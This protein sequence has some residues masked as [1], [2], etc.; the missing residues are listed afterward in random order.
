MHTSVLMLWAY[1]DESG[2]HCPQTGHLKKLTVGGCIAPFGAWETLSA[3][4]AT[5]TIRMGIPMFHMA[6]FERRTPPFDWPNTLRNERLNSLLGLI[7][8]A[9]PHCY[10]FTNLMRSG[11]ETASIYER[12]AMDLLVELGMYDDEFAVVFAHHPEFGR[13]TWLLDS[14]I[15]HG[16]SRQ[17]RSCTVA[18]P[19]DTCPLQAADI[20]AYEMCRHE[21]WTGIPER[22]PLKR[23][24][25]L[26]CT[27]RFSAAAE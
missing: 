14:L 21:R 12:C 6:D 5:A 4:W 9:K 27:F 20:V 25:E 24:R 8:E 7:G 10:S 2:H 19:V 13:H 15:K 23:M 11:E 3:E 26:G 18:S 16:M 1:F 22:Y 17:I